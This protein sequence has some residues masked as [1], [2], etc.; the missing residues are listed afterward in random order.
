[1]A[2]ARRAGG[3]SGV[4]AGRTTHAY[5]CTTDPSAGADGE[6]PFDAS[7]ADHGRSGF[8][9]SSDTRGAADYGHTRRI[10]ERGKRGV[11]SRRPQDGSGALRAGRQYATRVE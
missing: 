7:D 10:A 9:R 11:S 2:R 8:D 4:S 6:H 1:M 3:D 5:G